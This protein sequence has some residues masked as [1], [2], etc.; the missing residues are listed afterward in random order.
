M[1][2]WTFLLFLNVCLL[3]ILCGCKEASNTRSDN[4]II[5]E[6]ITVYGKSPEKDMDRVTELLSELSKQ[7]KATAKTWQEI[8]SYWDY[9]NNEMSINYQML[10][11]N[12]SGKNDMC[13]VILGFQ[14]NPDGSMKDE[15][16]GRLQTALNCAHQY[17]D[18]YIL[19]TGGGTASANK[20]I[21]EADRMARWLLENGVAESRI[22]VE[23]RSLS[24][25][26]NAVYSCE[27]L[28]RDY[29]NIKSVAIVSSDYH[30]AWGSV[31]FQT[32]FLLEANGQIAVTANAAYAA[33]SQTNYN[34]L[35]FQTSGILE[36]AGIR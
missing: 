11:D 19:C 21:T 25:V 7:N 27:I 36:L 16:I 1:K 8:M 20:D 4:E 28:M 23:N 31:L 33:N 32:E 2:K 3:L 14:L 30:I 26:K 18:A 13:I 5:K 12:L 6:M 34:I 10:P 24:T 15:L 22:I 29:P 9:A 35:Q 17:P